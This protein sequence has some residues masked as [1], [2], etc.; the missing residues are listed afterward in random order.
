MW[1][2]DPFPLPF[3]KSKR[4]RAVKDVLRIKEDRL[5]ERKLISPAQR[6]VG[7]GLIVL[8]ALIALVGLFGYLAGDWQIAPFAA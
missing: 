2:E 1:G 6:R 4:D 5:R 3:E 8:G 7:F